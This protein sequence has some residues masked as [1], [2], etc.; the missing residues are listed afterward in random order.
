MCRLSAPTS[1]SDPPIS[2][3]LSD[4]ERI[5]MVQSHLAGSHN[6][7]MWDRSVCETRPP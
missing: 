5:G 6:P 7:S 4:P 2:A 3:F 1:E